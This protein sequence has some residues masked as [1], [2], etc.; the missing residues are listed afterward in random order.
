M[1]LIKLSMMAALFLA[2]AAH[3]ALANGKMSFDDVRKG[4]LDCLNKRAKAEP[5]SVRSNSAPEGA[6]GRGTS[7]QGADAAGAQ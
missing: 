4:S 7:A 2:F 1:K 6:E 5:K 3:S